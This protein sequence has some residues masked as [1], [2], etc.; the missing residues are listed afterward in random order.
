MYEPLQ[1]TLIIMT[2]S[3]PVDYAKTYFLHLT[4]TTIYGEP[5]YSSLTKL[6]SE[7]KVNAFK[8]TLDLGGGGH[9]HLGLVL[10]P[11]EYS[12]ISAVPYACPLHPGTINFPNGTS[13]PESIQLTLTHA[14]AIRVFRDMVDLEKVFINIT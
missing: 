3:G 14:D 10:T 11:H 12:I 5:D 9:G 7:L 1:H 8:V 2:L 13:Q 6:K 4:L